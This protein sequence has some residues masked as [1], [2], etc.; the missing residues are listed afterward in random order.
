MKLLLFLL[1][2]ALFWFGVRILFRKFEK[3]TV[4][5]PELILDQLLLLMQT[6]KSFDFVRSKLTEDECLAL[7]NFSVEPRWEAVEEFCKKSPS[8]ALTLLKSFR[9]IVLLRGRLRLKVLGQTAQAKLQAV[10]VAALYAC[11]NGYILSLKE[12]PFSLSEFH[13][14][15]LFTTS[16]ILFGV[17]LR[18]MTE[19]SKFKDIDP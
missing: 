18:W 13:G 11:V 1:I 7:K 17:G 5:S 12:L 10:I 8:Q 19:I 3:K 2:F 15:A 6:G 14:K 16:L 9:K 4:H